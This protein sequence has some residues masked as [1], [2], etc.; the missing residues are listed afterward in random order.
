MKTEYDMG[1]IGLGTM[2]RNLLL[3]IADHGFSAIGLDQDQNKVNLV[4]HEPKTIASFGATHD[5]EIFVSQ[6]RKPRAVLLL[7]P[8]GEPLDRVLDEITPLLVPGDLVIDAGNSHFKDTDGREK[9][10]AKKGICFFGMGVSGGEAGA[11][12]GPS[13]MPG[14]DATAYERVRPIFEA[15]AAKVDGKPCVTYLGPRSSGH[16]V[17]MV[18]N[19]IEYGLMQL[20][21]ETYYLMKSAL[22]LSDDE[23]HAVYREWNSSELNSYLLEITSKIFLKEDEK[24]HKRLI[25]VILDVAKQKGTGMWTCQN[26][27]ELQV[28]VPTLDAAVAMRDFSTFDTD[29][30]QANTSLIGPAFNPSFKRAEL[31]N[32]LKNA[33]Y[34]SSIMTYAQGMGLL[35]KASTF[36][37]YDLNLEAIA[38]IWRGGCI[39]RA[40]VLEEIASAFHRMPE[41]TNLLLDPHL[42]G[43]VGKRENDLRNIVQ[44]AASFGF[45]I[46]AMMASLSY[47]DAYRSSWLP[48]NL[49]QA[50]RDYFGAHTYERIDQNG[51]FHSDWD[52]P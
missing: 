41:L 6:L 48:A 25:D 32:Q 1:I 9:N 46:P 8:A 35:Q 31:I 30:K 52:Q 26:A 13:L 37:Q 11:R 4:G 43:E 33:Y 19:G 40:G 18:H 29:R 27:M 5:L 34:G 3:N 44:I 38:R 23:C 17:K 45:P 47:Y 14:G 16:Y 2:G 22:H 7:V 42:G 15:I 21:A 20:I 28:P 12:K 51:S 49:I 24:T 10:L 39:I 50:Q 36:Y